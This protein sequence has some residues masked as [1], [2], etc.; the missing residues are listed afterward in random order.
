MELETCLGFNSVFVLKLSQGAAIT[1]RAS[2]ELE[3]TNSDRGRL[4]SNRLARTKLK[5]LKRKKKTFRKL[6]QVRQNFPFFEKKTTSAQFSFPC[7]HAVYNMVKNKR[8]TIKFSLCKFENLFQM[9]TCFLGTELRCLI[10]TNLQVKLIS[11]KPPLAYR[12]FY[13][14]LVKA[15]TVLP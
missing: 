11:V 9:P 8:L 14:W 6:V 2:C 5:R 4:H 1:R 12:F 3:S 15:S 7:F 10:R 13:V